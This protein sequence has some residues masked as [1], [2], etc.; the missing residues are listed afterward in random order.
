[1]AK[2]IFVLD[3]DKTLT[4]ILQAFL[5][6]NG[7]EVTVSNDGEDALAKIEHN[8]PDLLVLDV[9]M[10]GMN[11]YA[12]LFEMRKFEFGV[13][14]PVIVLTCKEEM[15]DIFKVEGVKEYL[16]KPFPNKDLLDKIKKYV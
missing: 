12:F 2:K 11:G 9:V 7:Y 15:A 13:A 8:R 3:D 10:P 1:M 4:K 5:Q 14:I 16:I 6:E